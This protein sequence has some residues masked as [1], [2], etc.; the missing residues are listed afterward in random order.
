MVGHARYGDSD[1]SSALAA[2]VSPAGILDP[3]FGEN[4][5]AV[6]TFGLSAIDSQVFTAAGVANGR[7]LAAGGAIV[8]DDEISFDS[9]VVRLE[10]DSMF[11]DGFE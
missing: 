1:W 8:G 7:I 6:F 11:V 9:I 5:K 3:T 4:G 10:N 2:R